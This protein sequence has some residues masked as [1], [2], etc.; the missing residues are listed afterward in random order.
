[1][2]IGTLSSDQQM[3]YSIEDFETKLVE[4]DEERSYE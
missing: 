4:E 3:K 2:H 1:M